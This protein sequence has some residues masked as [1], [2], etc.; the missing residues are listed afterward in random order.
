MLSAVGHP[1]SISRSS[2]SIILAAV[3]G[4]LILW[5]GFWIIRAAHFHVLIDGGIDSARARGH[6]ITY[7]ARSMGGFPFAVHYHFSNLSW[8]DKAGDSAQAADITLTAYPWQWN[9]FNL[10]FRQSAEATVTLPPL[11][12]ILTVQS[13]AGKGQIEL[14]DDGWSL[15]RLRLKEARGRRP[16]HELFTADEMDLTAQRPGHKPKDHTEVGLSFSGAAREVALKMKT[17][18]PLPFGTAID[19]FHLDLRV[20][21]S[22]PDPSKRESVDAWNTESGVV[23]CDAFGLT[24]GPLTLALTGTLGLDNDLQP[25]AAFSG[26]LSNPAAVIKALL[27]TGWIRGNS[28]T[29]L[30]AAFGQFPS[31]LKLTGVS[32]VLVPINVQSG[33][34]YLGPVLIFSFPP[35]DWRT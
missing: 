33:G 17:E 31:P 15:A 32:G 7:E 14:K 29:I 10:A 16:D 5:S 35:L 11:K 12:D 30:T 21:G 23:E 18:K 26:P 1:V 13:V 9:A 34:I 24:W 25:E 3:A 28:A 4:V 22:P 19:A 8:H 27:D 2:R 20:M 6:E